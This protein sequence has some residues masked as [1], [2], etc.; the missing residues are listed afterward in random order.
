MDGN[1]AD[2]TNLQDLRTHLNNLEQQDKL[3]RVTRPINKD[4]E[5]MP[6]VRWQFRGLPEEQRRGFYFEH[7]TNARAQ[8]IPGG[9][10]V[11]LYPASSDVSAIGMGCT[12][13]DL[14]SPWTKE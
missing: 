8:R 11:G 6:L 1:A 9:V 4:T 7:V 10:A 5:L 3:T 2:K 12:G 14:R 13:P